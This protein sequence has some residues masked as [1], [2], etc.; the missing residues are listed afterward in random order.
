[1]DDVVM[2]SSMRCSSSVHIE[3]VGCFLLRRACLECNDAN[4]DPSSKEAAEMIQEP[5]DQQGRL[6]AQALVAKKNDL[7]SH[8]D[9]EPDDTP[10]LW[11][12]SN[13]LAECR[14]VRFV[15]FSEDEVI[16]DIPH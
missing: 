2:Q 9:D 13:E 7:D 11:C 16:E 3:E 8:A 1:M 12:A 14:R 4:D 15:H 10:A 5:C 6:L